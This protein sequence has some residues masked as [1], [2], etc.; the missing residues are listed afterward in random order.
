MRRADKGRAW[1]PGRV[2]SRTREQAQ[3]DSGFSHQSRMCRETG[4][5]GEDDEFVFR[6]VESTLV[7]SKGSW[8]R[9]GG[10]GLEREICEAR[11]RRSLSLWL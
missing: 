8:Q 9:S 2:A 3:T 11:P 4:G 10:P 1:H 7:S 5:L 6:H